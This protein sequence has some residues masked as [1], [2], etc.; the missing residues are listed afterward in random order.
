MPKRKRKTAA[1]VWAV[2]EALQNGKTVR[3]AAAKNLLTP[4]TVRRW[5]KSYGK[6]TSL[7][8]LQ[9]AISPED[10]RYVAVMKRLFEEKFK[11][12]RKGFDWERA[13][14]DRLAKEIGIKVVKNLGDNVYSIR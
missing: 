8:E 11:K 3:E 5:N 4:E 13:D 2:I 10:N 1:E 9:I 14:L 7:E 6:F 12:G